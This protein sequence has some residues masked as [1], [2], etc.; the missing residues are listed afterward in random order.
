ML[1]TAHPERG[2]VYCRVIETPMDLGKAW[3]QFM[4]CTDISGVR[5][6]LYIL[7]L[8]RPVPAAAACP[9]PPYAAVFFPPSPRSTPQ[10]SPHA[11]PT[12]LLHRCSHPTAQ[13]RQYRHNLGLVF[14]NAKAFHFDD[15]VFRSAD[16]CEALMVQLWEKAKLEQQVA[17]EEQKQAQAEGGGGPARGGAGAGAAGGYSYQQHLLAQQQQREQQQAHQR[18][19]RPASPGRPPA[20]VPELE[21]LARSLR[22]LPRD[23]HREV[24]MAIAGGSPEALE[25]RPR[26][27]PIRPQAAAMARHAGSASLRGWTC[28]N[29]ARWRLEKC[30]CVAELRAGP[31][32]CSRVR[33]RFAFRLS[34]A[35]TRRRGSATWASSTQRRCRRSEPSWL[36]NSTAGKGAEGSEW[37][38]ECKPGEAAAG[39]AE[40]GQAGTT[41]SEEAEAAGD[42][43]ITPDA[44]PRPAG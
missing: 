8:L 1:N 17:E 40:T 34:R 9:V 7:P 31:A 36:R 23:R 43:R 3:E 28:C 20:P 33:R 35:W 24:Y 15:K 18:G 32:A 4:T 42:R 26:G 5:H 25:V 38:H 10:L 44:P 13:V 19:A 2:D 6:S 29:R 11:F 37:R 14:V 27:H 30:E 41:S 39:L 12:L 21:A 22:Q 16:L